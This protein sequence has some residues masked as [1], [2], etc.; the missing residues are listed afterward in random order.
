MHDIP[1]CC[2]GDCDC[3]HGGC[4]GLDCFAAGCIAGDCCG[5]S[6][7]SGNNKNDGCLPVMIF[8]AIVAIIGGVV[9]SFVQCHSNKEDDLNFNRKRAAK[10]AKALVETKKKEHPEIKVPEEKSSKWEKTKKAIHELTA[11]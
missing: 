3:G 9:T 8:L 10:E 7:N 1:D 4:D 11:P 6:N 5:S 2:C